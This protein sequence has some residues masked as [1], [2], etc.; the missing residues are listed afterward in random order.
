[1]AQQAHLYFH[2]KWV[3]CQQPMAL[4][5]W[6]K[7]QI[8][9]KSRLLKV[10]FLVSNQLGRSR[11]GSRHKTKQSGLPA[12][13]SCL[14]CF[15]HVASACSLKRIFMQATYITSNTK[16]GRWYVPLN[17]LIFYKNVCGGD[18]GCYHSSYVLCL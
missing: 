10:Y 5:A 6:R 13:P 17:S 15:V 12:L 1:M 7:P 8:S 4:L 14:L 2:A 11:A 18:G 16:K 3:G 9:K